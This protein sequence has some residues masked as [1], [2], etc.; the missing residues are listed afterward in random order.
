MGTLAVPYHDFAVLIVVVMRSV[1]IVSL[2]RLPRQPRRTASMAHLPVES[3][4]MLCKMEIETKYKCKRNYPRT[5]RT[6]RPWQNT[7]FESGP[8]FGGDL[9]VTFSFLELP[10]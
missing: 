10:L 3:I 6:F 2:A 1:S 5:S 7:N 4:W 9:D 8:H